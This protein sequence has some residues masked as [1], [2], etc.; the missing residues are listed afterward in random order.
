M[1]AVPS[2]DGLRS[3]EHTFHAP[4]QPGSRCVDCHMPAKTYMVVDPRR[5]HGFKLPR[6]DLAARTGAPDGC[7][8][9]HTGKDATWAAARIAEW[10]RPDRRREPDFGQA[11]AADRAGAPGAAQRLIKLADDPS[12]P[13][14][15]RATA[16]AA[17]ERH[18]DQ[19]AFAA[20]QRGLADPDAIIR[21]AAV[22]ALGNADPRLRPQ[23]LLPLLGDPVRAV[24]LEAARVLAPVSS[25]D[26]PPDQRVQL[27]RAFADY[28]A[29]QSD[30]CSIA[31]RA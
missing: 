20:I 29:A 22:G 9:C 8:G 17:L 28:E 5:D 2:A 25:L 3:P 26:L 24:R 19:P 23:A 14:I 6:P 27:E 10:Y 4:G 16:V 12:A 11:L 31:P 1:R 13:G 7:T 15:A 21:L 30:A 18:L